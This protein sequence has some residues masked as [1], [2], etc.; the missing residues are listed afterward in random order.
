VTYFSTTILMPVAPIGAARPGA[1]LE[2]GNARWL[3]DG[4]KMV[5]DIPAAQK[6]RDPDRGVRLWPWA[7][8]TA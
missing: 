8:N 3:I 7:R 6:R 1:S 5:H 2:S 4:L